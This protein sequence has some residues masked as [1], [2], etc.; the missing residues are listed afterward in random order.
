MVNQTNPYNQIERKLVKIERAR[1]GG[2]ERGRE[3][4]FSGL[5]KWLATVQTG[6][7]FAREG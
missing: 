1:E 3:R 7:N 4:D 5:S 2:R 6:R